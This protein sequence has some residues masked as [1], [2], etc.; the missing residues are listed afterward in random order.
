[1]PL[2]KINLKTPPH[3]GITVIKIAFVSTTTSV[4]LHIYGRVDLCEKLVGKISYRY[5]NMTFAIWQCYF[6][7]N[8]HK[9][10]TV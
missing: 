9:N 7:H 10:I 2:G 5:R 1:M 4:L 6:K 3:V 8:K